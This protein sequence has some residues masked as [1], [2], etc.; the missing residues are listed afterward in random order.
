MARTKQ[1]IVTSAKADQTITVT[2]NSYE[3][4]PKYHKRYLVSTKFRAHDAENKAKEGDEV[5]IAEAR[6]LS[7]TK[8]WTLKEIINKQS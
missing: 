1:G 8:R 2:V 6:P 4:H 5:V 7:A 3:T